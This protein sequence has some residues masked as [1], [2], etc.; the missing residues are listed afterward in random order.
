MAKQWPNNGAVLQ[1]VIPPIVTPLLYRDEIDLE[2]TRRLLEHILKSKV[3]GIFVLGTTGEFSSFSVSLRRNFIRLCCAIVNGRVPVLIGIADSA[4]WTT[5]ELARVAKDAGAS[6][7][8]LTTPYYFPMEQSEVK[9]YVEQVLKEVTLPVMLYNMPG[10]TKVWLEVETIRELSIHP[11]I[12]GVKDSSGDLDYFANLCQLKVQ[13]PDWSIFIGPEHLLDQAI[14]LGADGGVNGGANVNP[15]LFVAACTAALNGN[16]KECNEWMNKVHAFQSIYQVGS[17][18]GFRFITA[19][20]CAL[21]QQGICNDL[22]ALPLLPFTDD[23]K[24]E[25]RKVLADLQH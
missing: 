24:V 23:E 1:G 7:V 20:K 3:A 25:M 2:G 8:V 17:G 4:F 22:V 11:Q 5:V 19:T 14:S 6:A 16:K 15:E 21:A 9:C 12:I 18:H 10:L 13:R